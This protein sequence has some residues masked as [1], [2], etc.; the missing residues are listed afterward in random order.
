MLSVSP[1]L[2]FSCPPCPDRRPRGCRPGVGG[3]VIV[4]GGDEGGL[5]LLEL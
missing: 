2:L 3:M 1:S 5:Q 4:G